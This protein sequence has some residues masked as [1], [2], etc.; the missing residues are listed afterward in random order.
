MRV[1]V[2]RLSQETMGDAWR[3]PMLTSANCFLIV[4]HSHPIGL[5]VAKLK[6]KE[7]RNTKTGRK[8]IVLVSAVKD[9]T[10]LPW[11]SNPAI[12]PNHIYGIGWVDHIE[13]GG[14]EA[15]AAFEW[16]FDPLYVLPNPISLHGVGV[17]RGHVAPR[18]V[19][20]SALKKLNAILCALNAGMAGKGKSGNPSAWG[21]NTFEIMG[22]V[23]ALAHPT[24]GQHLALPVAV[25]FSEVLHKAWELTMVGAL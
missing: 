21:T 6:S 5:F 1:G 3:W 12:K 19:H 24:T 23:K 14:E 18:P 13:E 15:Y 9:S 10:K 16:V 4:L 7:S 11:D 20:A 2:R 25:K 8:L 22:E 17:G